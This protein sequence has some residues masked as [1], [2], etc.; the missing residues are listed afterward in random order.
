[1]ACPFNP[2]YWHF[3]DRHRDRLASNHRIGR[4]YAT[5]DRMGE[6]KQADYLTS[7]ERFLD[8]LEPA[9]QGWARAIAHDD[10]REAAE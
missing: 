9:A 10:E 6:D 7:A 4:I 1:D 2:L 8:T 5:W 3:M